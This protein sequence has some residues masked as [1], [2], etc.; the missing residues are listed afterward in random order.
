MWKS[1][2]T[3]NFLTNEILLTFVCSQSEIKRGYYFT[4]FTSNW[5][6]FLFMVVFWVFSPYFNMATN[7]FGHFVVVKTNWHQF[8]C[9]WPLLMINWTIRLSKFA[10]EITC[11]GLVISAATLTV[12]WLEL[13]SMRGQTHKTLTSIC[14]CN[15]C[16]KA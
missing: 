5:I 9:V 11:Q 7:H 3:V 13:S 6:I 12:S 2:W 14:W 10:V 1:T 4:M 16:I 15:D 8:L